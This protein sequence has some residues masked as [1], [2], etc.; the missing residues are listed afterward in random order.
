[1]SEKSLKMKLLGL[2]VKFY[3]SEWLGI[4]KAIKNHTIV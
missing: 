2:M 3:Y 1:M 4:L